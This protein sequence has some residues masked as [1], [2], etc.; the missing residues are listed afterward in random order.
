VPVL[1]SSNMCIT[2]MLLW[3]DWIGRSDKQSCACIVADELCPE[4][5]VPLH[6]EWAEQDAIS[7]KDDLWHRVLTEQNCRLGRGITETYWS[8]LTFI[9]KSGIIYF[10]SCLFV[11]CKFYNFAS[12]VARDS[13]SVTC[14]QQLLHV[15]PPPSPPR[16]L[17]SSFNPLNGIP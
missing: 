17:S 11:D 4:A 8:D 2:A 1:R 5:T 7:Q 16:A 3:Q 9:N 15:S 10:S 12:T 13:V 14:P 6:V